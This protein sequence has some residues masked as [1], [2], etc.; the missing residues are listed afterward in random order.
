MRSS[1]VLLFVATTAVALAACAQITGISDYGDLPCAG[2]GCFDV[3]PPG[4]GGRV[5]ASDAGADVD[6][7]PDV[8]VD[9]VKV[10][11]VRL[12]PRWRMPNP[13][14]AAVGS[15]TFLDAGT[16]SGLA[17]VVD[18]VTGLEWQKDSTAASSLAAAQTYCAQIAAQFSKP[19]GWTVPTRIELTTVLAPDRSPTLDPSFAPGAGALFWTASS[20]AG[21]KAYVIDFASGQVSIKPDVGGAARVRCVRGVKK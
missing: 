3:G 20:L 7:L 14:D 13:P 18:S 15:G 19:G 9:V 2:S 16:T 21:G 17:T 11:E 5:D 4:E 10:A 8:T 1:R 6:Q 12:W